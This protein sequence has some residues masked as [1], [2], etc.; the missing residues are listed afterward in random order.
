MVTAGERRHLAGLPVHGL[1]DVGLRQHPLELVEDVVA[2]ELNGGVSMAGSLFVAA[3]RSVR[4]WRPRASLAAALNDRYLL[5]GIPQ[6][7]EIPG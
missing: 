1:E 7:R 6:R 5:G 3:R 4:Y 2:M